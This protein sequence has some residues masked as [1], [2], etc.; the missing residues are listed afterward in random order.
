VNTETRYGTIERITRRMFTRIITSLSHT[1]QEEELSVAQVA[2]LYLL[3]EHGTMR[4]GDVA[5]VLDRAPPA[6]SRMIDDLVASGLV[7]RKEDPTDRRARCLSLTSKGSKFIARAGE[8]RVKTILEATR[9]LPEQ[10]AE[11]FLS[12]VRK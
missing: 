10:A 4:I 6:T 9:E 5:S 3:D 11:L 1:L 12:T 2:T 8:A 7:E